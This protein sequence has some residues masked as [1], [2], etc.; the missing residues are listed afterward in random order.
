MNLK[1]EKFIVYT[2]ACILAV[3]MLFWAIE[4]MLRVNH[5]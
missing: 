5:G 3:C 2:V 4:P 1:L